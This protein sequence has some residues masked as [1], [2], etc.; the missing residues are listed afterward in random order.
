VTVDVL[1]D[2]LLEQFD[3]DPDTC[4]RETTAFL[5]KLYERGLIVVTQ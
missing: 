4:R 5:E 1:C 3:V 2:R